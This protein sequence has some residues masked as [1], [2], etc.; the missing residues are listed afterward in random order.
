MKRTPR[1]LAFH[2]IMFIIVLVV[3]AMGIWLRLGPAVHS[4]QT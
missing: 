1:R 4:Q 3:L 2:I